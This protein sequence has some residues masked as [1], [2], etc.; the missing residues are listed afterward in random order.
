M[1]QAQWDKTVM[2]L[3]LQTSGCN[4]RQSDQN[5]TAH[6]CL[7]ATWKFNFNFIKHESTFFKADGKHVLYM[8]MMLCTKSR[9]RRIRVLDVLIERCDFKGFVV[10][11]FKWHI[12][13]PQNNEG[14]HLMLD[15]SHL[16]ICLRL[17]RE[18]AKLNLPLVLVIRPT[19]NLLW[20]VCYGTKMMEP[21][22]SF[23][24]SM[25]LLK[26]VFKEWNLVNQK[27]WFFKKKGK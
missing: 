7:S 21:K 23:M 25:N 24:A 17:E 13:K 4:N 15:T 9:G 14:T 12:I 27:A 20:K 1:H 11:V 10:E 5:L 19:K 26:H 6:I 22:G 3:T 18:Y 2:K 16:Y 8:L